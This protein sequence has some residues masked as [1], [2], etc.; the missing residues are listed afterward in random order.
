MVNKRGYL[1]TLEALIGIIIVFG[2]ILFVNQKNVEV[3]LGVPGIVESSQRAILDQ[4]SQDADYRECVLNYDSGDNPGS[5]SSV[6][7]YITLPDCSVDII[8]LI[9]GNLPY[10]YN[11]ACEI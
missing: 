10:G 4:I 5:C 7:Y 9:E 6:G 3:E 1:R 8:D 2:V 11:Y